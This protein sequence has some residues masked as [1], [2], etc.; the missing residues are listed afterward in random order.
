VTRIHRDNALL[1]LMRAGWGAADI[2]SKKRT[3]KARERLSA[4]CMKMG[5]EAVVKK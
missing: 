3:Q 5:V 4:L 2:G 1:R